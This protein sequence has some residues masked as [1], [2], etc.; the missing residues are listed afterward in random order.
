MWNNSCLRVYS[1][2]GLNLLTNVS[3][4]QHVH[5]EEAPQGDSKVLQEESDWIFLE[6]ERF[7]C[8]IKC[9]RTTVNYWFL[10]SNLPQWCRFSQLRLQPTLS[11]SWWRSWLVWVHYESLQGLPIERRSLVSRSRLIK[12]CDVQALRPQLEWRRSCSTTV[13]GFMPFHRK[14]IW[15]ESHLQPQ[16]LGHGEPWLLCLFI[17]PLVP[18]L[19]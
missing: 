19:Q 6:S 15:A 5:E 11:L 14:Q 18:H 2:W 4:L 17:T 10:K 8:D 3:M 9:L 12:P 7:Q 13:R 1:I 16:R